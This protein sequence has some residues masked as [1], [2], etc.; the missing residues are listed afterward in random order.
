MSDRNVSPDSGQHWADEGAWPAAPGVHRI[1]LPLPTD[2]LRAV[3]VY[4]IETDGAEGGLT[5]VD[6][7]WAIEAGRAA[8]DKGLAQI[9]YAASDIRRFLV[10]HVHRDH[11][12]QAVVV[13]REF[14]SRIALGLAD[15][16]TLDRVHEGTDDNRIAALLHDAGAADLAERWVRLVDGPGPDLSHWG[17]PDE[18]LD[19]DVDLAVGARTLRAVA[20]PGH[21]R[22]HYV[23]A[24]PDAGLLFAGDHVLPTI[25]PSIGFEPVPASLPLGDFLS[26]LTKVR[27]MP[28]ALLLPAHGPVAPSV[29]A[30]VDELLAH[31]DER[32]AQ[33][34]RALAPGG[35]SAYDAAA[36]LTWTRH[37]HPLA[38]LDTFNQTLA[39]LETRAHLEL[40]VA[41][42]DAVA[43]D[44]A[45]G[46]AYAPSVER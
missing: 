21:T 45:D 6:G 27:A 3:N 20:T 9:G 35:R 17:Y 42:G 31:H 25:T 40:L 18:W 36:R 15:K 29:H 26:S 4:A 33:C 38:D 44:T 11:Y 13:R 46:R 30:R 24:E 34:R 14:G 37:E 16:P 12:T 43:V 10:T 39:V 2:G 28:D 8:L 1:P 23:F 19:D 32:L 5:L 7:G 22:G 41:R